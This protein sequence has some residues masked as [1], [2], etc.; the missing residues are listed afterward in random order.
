MALNIK[1]YTNFSDEVKNGTVTDDYVELKLGNVVKF[2]YTCEEKGTIYP[3]YL[4]MN[5]VYEK[6]KIGK[7]CIFEIASDVGITHVKVPSGIKFTIDYITKG[8]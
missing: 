7:T 4:K 6:F 5:G 8:E 2:G 1:Q 3:I